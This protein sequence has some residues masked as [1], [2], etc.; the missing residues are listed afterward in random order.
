[1]KVILTT[2]VDTVGY[3]GEIKDVKRGLARNFLLPRKMAVEAT[4]GNVKVWEKKKHIIQKHQI[5][6]K[7]Q[8]V[9]LANRLN[10]V[11]CNI[12]VKVGEE[13][14]LFGSVTSQN[15][16]DALEELGFKISK[17]D[18]VMNS[19]IKETG[20]YDVTVKV[21]QDVNATIK[22]KVLDEEAPEESDKGSDVTAEQ[23]YP[24]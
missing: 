12:K 3:M 13:G 6:R 22:V 21:H 11:V 9:E 7:E 15:I 23:D 18:L 24:G 10:D 8:A 16:S 5:E 4:P 14:K 2:D 20:S 1:M 17:K 19:S